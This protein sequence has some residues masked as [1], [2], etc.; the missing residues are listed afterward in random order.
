VT[1]TENGK[2]GKV[3]KR[4]AVITQLV[5]KSAS[6]ELR[7]TK[8]LIEML[9]EIE[10][11]TDP[12]SAEKNPFGLSD[13]EVVHQLIT[14]LRRNMCHGCPRTAQHDVPADE[15]SLSSP[16]PALRERGDPARRAGWERAISHANRCASQRQNNDDAGRSA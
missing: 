3:T 4:E 10:R 5:N 2:R 9:R 12:A 1:V 6:A 16:S 11:K 15:A 14:R 13:K 7:A 8:M